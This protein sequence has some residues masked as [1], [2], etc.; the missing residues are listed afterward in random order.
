MEIS[1]GLA[2]GV[3]EIYLDS[4]T[5]YYIKTPALGFI[6]GRYEI[7][8][9]AEE[10]SDEG[11]TLNPTFNLGIKEDGNILITDY[12]DKGMHNDLFAVLGFLQFKGCSIEGLT[13]NV[14]LR[15]ARYSAA[16]LGL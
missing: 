3:Q 15:D 10:E 8:D 1:S 14:F 11:K 2:M 7:T 6:D 16:T 12:E 5:G 9:T 13:A 4:V